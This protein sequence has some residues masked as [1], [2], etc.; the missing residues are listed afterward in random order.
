MGDEICVQ[1]ALQEGAIPSLVMLMSNGTAMAKDKA[2]Q[3]LK[4][5]HTIREGITQW[6]R[7]DRA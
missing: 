6:T 5:F 1:M 2:G 3:L 7:S 4:L